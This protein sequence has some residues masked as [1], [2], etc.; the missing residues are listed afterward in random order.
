MGRDTGCFFLPSLRPYSHLVTFLGI[1]CVRKEHGIGYELHEPRPEI[2]LSWPQ[3]PSLVVKCVCRL[4]QMIWEVLGQRKTPRSNLSS[5]TSWLVNL[6]KSL[7]LS[8]SQFLQ[9]WDNI[10]L[11]GLNK[12]ISMKGL[13]RC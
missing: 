7:N 4:N 9:L 11:G 12:I 5:V 2:Y 3:C 10:N 13:F 8:E 6:E 1:S